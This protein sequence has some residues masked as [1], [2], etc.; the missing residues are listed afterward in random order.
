MASS[1]YL[2]I[3][4][5]LDGT[6]LDRD[7][8]SYAEAASALELV[9]KRKVPLLLASSKTRA[10]MEFYRRRLQ[11]E[12]PFIVENGAA[13]FIPTGYF[14]P[15]SPGL[16][17]IGTYS[18]IETGLP[19]STIREGLAQIRAKTGLSIRGFGDMSVED[20]SGLS[21][22]EHEQAELAMKRE[23]AE[24]FVM[25]EPRTPENLDFIRRAAEEVGL[26][27]TVGEKFLHLS[28]LHDKGRLVREL[29]ALFKQLL[30]RKD[31]RLLTAALGDGKNDIEMLAGCDFRFLI[32]KKNGL[33]DEEVL[34]RVPKVTVCEAGP[35]GW[36]R[37]VIELLES[38]PA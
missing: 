38:L 36:N 2:V 31:L 13:A 3:F 9:R 25:G 34:K 20:V 26:R 21:L 1:D 19:Y 35:S 14:G 12:Y 27:F 18:V 37:A 15:A 10:E 22:L 5:D 23:Y 7:T 11:N 17:R 28:G 33:P 8:Y 32:R 30:G 6:L 29:V 4:T 16:K 24:P